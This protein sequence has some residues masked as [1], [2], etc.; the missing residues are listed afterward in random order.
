MD[1]I[2]EKLYGGVAANL[3]GGRINAVSGKLLASLKSNVTDSGDIVEGTVQA[4]GPGIPYAAALEY[5]V[6]TKPHDIV[7][8]NANV[9]AFLWPGKASFR[10]GGS[11]GDVAFLKIVHHPG[12]KIPAF[13]YM[14]S[15]LAAMRG[16]ITARFTVIVS[17]AWA[18]MGSVG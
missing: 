5:G 7:P 9:L 2:V 17:K 4:G 18:R 11:T 6:V 8:V 10:P 15:V 3:S 13:S 14:R 16:E 12:S 1:L